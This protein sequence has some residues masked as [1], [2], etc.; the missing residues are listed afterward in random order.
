LFQSDD[1]KASGLNFE[2]WQKGN[3]F[4]LQK[5]GVTNESS[6]NWKII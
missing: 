4:L 2:D 5:I 6:Q 3:E 1:F